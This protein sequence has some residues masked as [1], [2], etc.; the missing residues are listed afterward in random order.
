MPEAAFGR[1]PIPGPPRLLSGVEDKRNFAVPDGE[2]LALANGEV[3]HT[4]G[5]LAGAVKSMSEQRDLSL[6]H[7]NSQRNEF[8]NW[9]ALTFGERALAEELR[10]NCSTSSQTFLAIERFLHDI[11][12]SQAFD[13]FDLLFGT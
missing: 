12:P 13:A 2:T 11:P 1:E 7:V 5:E 3:I 6:S 10:S 8:A 9:I 4:L